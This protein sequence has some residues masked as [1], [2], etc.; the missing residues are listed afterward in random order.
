MKLLLLAGAVAG[1]ARGWELDAN[2]AGKVGRMSILNGID[3][4]AFV[5]VVMVAAGAECSLVSF[6]GGSRL[7]PV[8]LLLVLLPEPVSSREISL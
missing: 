7:L 1:T 3:D 5:A 2:A 6:G 8:L 4:V